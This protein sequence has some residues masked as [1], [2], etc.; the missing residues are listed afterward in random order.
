MKTRNMKQSLLLFIVAFAAI[1]LLSKNV[2]ADGVRVVLGG[3]FMDYYGGF[4]DLDDPPEMEYTWEKIGGSG[5]ITGGI[6]GTG[7]DRNTMKFSAVGVG[8]VTIR[9]NAVLGNT[10]VRTKTR[11]YQVINP[12]ESY[13]W[14]CYELKS[15]EAGG[16]TGD[17][18]MSFK[19]IDSGSV[20]TGAT[21]TIRFKSWK[22]DDMIYDP[23]TV[24]YPTV[25]DFVWKQTGQGTVTEI[26]NA[27]DSRYPSRTFKAVN[28]GDITL[29]FMSKDGKWSDSVSFRIHPDSYVMSTLP[30]LYISRKKQLQS[31]YDGSKIVFVVENKDDSKKYMKK[32][33]KKIRI[34]SSDNTVA[35]VGEVDWD[36]TDYDESE[37][38]FEIPIYTHKAGTVTISIVD[39]KYGEVL[40]SVKLRITD[41]LVVSKWKKA[42]N[43]DG[44]KKYIE[45]GDPYVQV[46]AYEGD[47]VTLKLGKKSWTKTIPRS[48]WVKFKIPLFKKGTKGKVIFKK[49]GSPLT[50]T[51]NITVKDK[52]SV[53]VSRVTSSTN[54]MAI[55]VSSAV[56]GDVIKITAGKKKY[57]KKIKK[58]HYSEEEEG[59]YGYRYK[60]K[61]GRLEPGTKIKIVVYNKF[62]QVRCKKTVKVKS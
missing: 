17:T 55:D 11:T 44:E 49:A 36:N 6:Q 8:D 32:I 12:Y 25:D 50:I 4:I 5:E 28:I 18:T 39:D 22:S 19:D 54:K 48:R 62:K 58:T 51:R 31:S 56:K 38:P 45:Y 13:D 15:P 14:Y 33:I 47:T 20:R 2:R 26:S 9:L 61:I 37:V 53:K 35:T 30:N 59:N 60:Q 57:I 42:A 46:Y 24:H 3:T 1:F 40:D 43:I 27:E 10:V 23:A 41:S 7:S 29:T 16:F 52:I 21:F 34:V